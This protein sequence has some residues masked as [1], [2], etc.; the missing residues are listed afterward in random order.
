MMPRLDEADVLNGDI[1]AL[2]SPYLTANLWVSRSFPLIFDLDIM[3]TRRKWCRC[4]PSIKELLHF[5]SGSTDAPPQ[6]P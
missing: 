1:E 4:L 6:T 2:I 3:L 5:Q